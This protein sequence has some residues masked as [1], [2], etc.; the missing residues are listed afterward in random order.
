M[1]FITSNVAESPDFV[2]HKLQKCEKKKKPCLVPC[3]WKWHPINSNSVSW[4]RSQSEP[5]VKSSI[6]PKGLFID[7]IT[8]VREGGSSERPGEQRWN[9][10]WQTAQ[11]FVP[12]ACF[13]L[14]LLSLLFS[15]RLFS[16]H[17]SLSIHV[18][19]SFLQILVLPFIP[20]LLSPL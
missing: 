6:P 11:L 8:E 17:L 18:S 4:C 1:Y 16:I 5:R 7:A 10:P 12:P 14:L 20:P 19:S 15:H 13:L 2:E 9:R 3:T